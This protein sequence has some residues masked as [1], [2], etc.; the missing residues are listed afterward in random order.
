M[1]PQ[2]LAKQLDEALTTYNEE[3]VF[4]LDTFDQTHDDENLT[5]QDMED[6]GRQIYYLLSE[7][8]NSIVKFLKDN[9]Q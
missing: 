7:F 6:L 1:T 2:R 5:K 9:N 4:M 3:V 8:R